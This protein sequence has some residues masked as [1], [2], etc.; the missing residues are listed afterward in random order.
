MIS[1]VYQLSAA[2]CGLLS[3]RAVLL[4]ISAPQLILRCCTE[5]GQSSS[6]SRLICAHCLDIA[7]YSSSH[8]LPL[9]A[10]RCHSLPLSTHVYSRIVT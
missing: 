10:T 6:L 2:A 1:I 5:T 4:H 9:I 3:V 8:S 7:V